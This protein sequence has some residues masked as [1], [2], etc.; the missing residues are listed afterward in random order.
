VRDPDATE[1]L[2]MEVD[3][4]LEEVVRTDTLDAVTRRC[5]DCDHLF[6]SPTFD[7]EELSRL[8]SPE[9]DRA[10]QARYG[11]G[12]RRDGLSHEARAAGGDAG[13]ARELIDESRAYRPAFLRALVE[14]RRGGGVRSVLDLGGADG[15]NVAAFVDGRTTVC[16]YDLNPGWERAEGVDAIDDLGE[17]AARG[18]WDLLVSTHTLEHLT[19]PA[20]ELEAYDT[21]AGEE[22]LFYVEVPL[23]H[24]HARARRRWP[25]TWHVNLYCRES[26]RRLLA[27]AGWRP[28]FIERRYMPFNELRKPVFVGLFE[29]GPAASERGSLLRRRAELLGDLGM[30]ARLAIQRRILRRPP[31]LPRDVSSD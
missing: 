1:T 10:M 5:P 31:A 13:L 21:L 22:T 17:A 16:V 20:R 27:G 25:L 8:Y 24:V 26:L 28:L 30:V 29:R 15:S 4:I 23:E 12:E 3:A 9:F 11:R 19:E 18:P 7:E 6:L 14:G 2:L